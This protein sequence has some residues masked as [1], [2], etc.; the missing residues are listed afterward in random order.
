M[1]LGKAYDEIMD[2]IE[3]T[4]EMR[5]RVLRRVQAEGISPARPKALSVPR[6]KKYLSAAACLVLII[7][8][9]AVLPRLV[10]P[11]P[12]DEHVQTV[13]K[14]EEAAS[15]E[16]LSALVGFEVEAGFT[17]PFEPEETTYCSYW[18]E[19]AQIQYSAQGQTATYRQSAGTEDNSGDYNRYGD[20]VQIDAGGLTVTLKGQAGRYALALWTDGQFSY[21]LSL[22]QGM[23]EAGWLAVF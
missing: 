19:L 13:P 10:R 5:E 9:A 17:L 8:G 18:G 2:Q 1:T 3:V 12:P 22:S 16:E 15:R 7:A 6:L 23:T 11:Q 21:S 14:I 20:T 4:P